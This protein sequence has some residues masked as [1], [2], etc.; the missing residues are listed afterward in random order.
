MLV[1]PD[2]GDGP[3][4]RCRVCGEEKPETGF[5]PKR[6]KCR[7]CYAKQVKQYDIEHRDE[8]LAYRYRFRQ[9]NREM[10]IERSEK[11]RQENY[12]KEARRARDRYHKNRD[13]ILKWSYQYRRQRWE[14]GIDKAGG[15]CQLCKQRYHHIIY[16]F[17]HVNPAERKAHGK[18][19]VLRQE[20]E[21]LDKCALLCA[22]CHRLVTC[23][24][25]SVDWRKREGLGWTVGESVSLG[26]R[27]AI[28]QGTRRVRKGWNIAIAEAGGC[29][30]CCNK[31]YHRV[32]HDFHHVN[33]SDKKME[34][35]KAVQ[36]R[37]WKE[38]DKC[39]LLCAHCHRLIERGIILVEW[40]KRDGL[41][42]TVASKRSRSEDAPLHFKN[43][44]LKYTSTL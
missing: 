29:C 28:D 35:A 30:Q 41:G 6:R 1:S 23:N 43:R 33:S 39:A 44:V 17:H 8:K 18:D 19:A 32:L 10:L 16:D 31:T 36:T 11:Y 40:Q 22:H 5:L 37:R 12:A 25:V 34:P 42:W 7:T 24:L 3:L 4:K 38:L 27:E 2:I 15:C 14:V 26:E 20:W 21:E 13:R 9:Q